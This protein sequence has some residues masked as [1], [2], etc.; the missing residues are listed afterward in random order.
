MSKFKK[1]KKTLPPIST[2]SLPDIVFM[3]LF[4]FMVST[5][6][7]T[8]DLMLKTQQLPLAKTNQKFVHKSLVNTVFIGK[9]KDGKE[10][11]FL[12]LNDRIAEIHEIEAFIN[13]SREGKLEDEIPLM[14]TLIKSDV[15][16]KMGMVNDVKKQ[17][18]EADQLKISLATVPSK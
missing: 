2:A 10:G 6:M 15:N 13:N 16:V 12:Q 14:T 9:D 5:T 8:N 3:L 18:R 4:F 11:D 17:L 7:R 1:E